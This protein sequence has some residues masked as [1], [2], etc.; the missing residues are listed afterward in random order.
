MRYFSTDTTDGY[1]TPQG[2]IVVRSPQ[3]TIG[4]WK[5]PELTRGLIDPDGWLHT[6]DVGRMMEGGKMRIIDRVKN[7]FKL[8]QGEYIAPEKIENELQ[9]ST[10][11]SQIFIT[12]DSFKTYIVAVVIPREDTLKKWAEEHTL[13]YSY[14]GLCENAELK[15]DILKEFNKICKEC[16]F[17]GLECVRNIY[18]SPNPFTIE[19]DTLTPTLKVKRFQAGQLYKEQIADLYTQP[20]PSLN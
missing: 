12:G 2:E 11:V 9:K 17:N 20:V 16:H 15:L 7:I 8:S 6:G 19:E 5:N 4:Y 10:F 1:P 3:N 13:K 14:S 18:L